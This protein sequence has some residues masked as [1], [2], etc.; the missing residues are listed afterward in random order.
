M[1]EGAGSDTL[2][3]FVDSDVLFAGAASSSEHS[4]SQVV[5]RI[6]ELTLIDAICTQ[7]VVTEV[8]RNLSSSLPQA[9]P[10]MRMLISRCLRVIPNLAAREIVPHWGRADPKDLPLLVAAIHEECPF[11]TTFN[12]RDFQP[13]HPDVEVLRPGELIRR[14][15]RHLRRISEA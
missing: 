3:V 1:T 2:C 7:Q 9:L 11:L 12:V 15:R 13:G 8:E 10:A 4:A 5:L 14:I 6:S